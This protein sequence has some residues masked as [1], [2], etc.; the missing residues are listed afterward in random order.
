MGQ[1]NSSNPEPDQALI[2]RARGGDREAFDALVVRYQ[3]QVYNMSL[4]MLGN[5]EDALDCAQEIFLTVYRSLERF[6]ARAKFS[7]WLYRVTVNRCRDELRRRGMVKHTRPL[8]LDARRGDED[9]PAPDPPAR[10]PSPVQ[11]AA[12]STPLSCVVDPTW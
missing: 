12:R 10:E 2:E 5:R 6:E 3:D 8:S 11:S 4:R 7:T 9:N 1:P